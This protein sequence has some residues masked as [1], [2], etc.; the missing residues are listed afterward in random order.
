MPLRHSVRDY[1]QIIVVGSEDRSS[2]TKRT[3]TWIH[4]T[5]VVAARSRF[6]LKLLIM[7]V[8]PVKI[9]PAFK[10]IQP[11]IAIIVNLPQDVNRTR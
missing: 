9:N 10:E 11:F 2:Y 1:S 6:L 4:M 5:F 8:Y 7:L 3:H